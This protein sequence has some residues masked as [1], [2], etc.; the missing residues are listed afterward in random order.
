M[1]NY[2]AT[3]WGRLRPELYSVDLGYGIGLVATDVARITLFAL[4]HK[5]QSGIHTASIVCE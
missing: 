5:N 3:K 2:T 1:L 4:W